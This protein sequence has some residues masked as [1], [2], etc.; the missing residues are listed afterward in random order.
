MIIRKIQYNINYSHILSFKDDYKKITAPYFGWNKVKYSIEQADTFHEALRLIFTEY[1][2]IMHF[3]KDGITIMFEGS[4]S[5]FLSDSSL[6]KE[7]FVMYESI[8]HLECYS[9]TTRHDLTV[10]AVN[11]AEPIKNTDFI[12]FNPVPEKLIEFACIYHYKMSDND[13]N[14]TFGNFIPND[15]EK[16]DLSP[17]KTKHNE[18]LFKAENGKM[19]EVRLMSDEEKPTFSKLK[20]VVYDVNKQIQYF[21]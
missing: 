12:K 10:Y 8:T 11:P 9:K 6:V 20:K 3:R 16:Y 1:N 4:D 21:I 15:I 18:D 13:I 14:L 19:C 17:F 2:T 5:E 7:F